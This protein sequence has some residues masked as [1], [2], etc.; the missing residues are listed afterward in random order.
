MTVEEFWKRFSTEEGCKQYLFKKRWPDGFICPHCSYEEVYHQQCRDLFWCRR[1]G[2]QASV[3]RETIF[4]SKNI[5]LWKWF[6]AIYRVA[7]DKKGFSAMQLMKEIGVSYPTAWFLLQKI[8]EAMRKRDEVYRLHGV[9]EM[10]D[11]YIGGKEE[12]K[13]GRGVKDKIPIIVAVE[14]RE[15][16]KGL[17]PGYTSLC[18]A[19]DLSSNVIGQFAELRIEPGT[20]IKT[21]GW[22]SYNILGDK[23]FDHKVIITGGGEAAGKL[24][25]WVH[26]IIGNLKRFLLGTHH[27]IDRK[28]LAS[29]VAEFSYRLNRRFHEGDLFEHLIHACLSIPPITQRGMKN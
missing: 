4:H 2:Y 12:G 3:T 6:W 26:V 22:P 7:Q 11:G 15:T 24:F 21:D 10:D 29:Y 20:T 8:R 17:K 16:E 23:G 5:G 1:C 27:H 14:E 13:R 19:K 28:Y 25:P 9:V 18:V